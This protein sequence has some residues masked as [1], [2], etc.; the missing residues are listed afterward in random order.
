[1]PTFVTYFM[2]GIM[3]P[4]LFFILLL[5]LI[6]P[7][8]ANHNSDID[9]LK[10]ELLKHG[11]DTVK[12][13]LLFTIAR[14]L[15]NSR[16]KA[17]A[18]IYMDEYLRLSQKIGYIE[19]LIKYYDTEGQNLRNDGSYSKAMDYHYMAMN[20]AEKNNVKKHLPRIYNNIGVIYRRLDDYTNG[21]SY[22]LK[23]LKT[24]EDLADTSTIGYALNSVGNIYSLM[25]QYDQA[26]GYFNKSLE[27]AHKVGNIRS[28]A[29]NYN[30]IGEVYEFMGNYGEAL[31]Y[32]LISL[33]YNQQINNI[34]GLGIS[35]DCVG[36]I[37]R[38]TKQNNKA[39]EYF[40][41][42]AEMHKKHKEHMFY[43]ISLKNI[44]AVYL[45]LNDLAKAEQYLMQALSLAKDSRSKTTLSQTYELLAKVEELKHNYAKALHYERLHSAY[46]DSVWN[47]ENS[48]RMAK[49]QIAYNTE[50]Q[51]SE[52]EKLELERS[53]NQQVI[54]RKNNQNIFLSIILGLICVL[55]IFLYRSN[56]QKTIINSQL[57]EQA[58]IISKKNS[59]LVRHKKRIETFN[60]RITDSL[61]YAQRV[62][63]A[64]LPTH[65]FLALVFK[66]YMIVHLPLEKV[67]GDFYWVHRRDNEILFAVADS[68]G[69]GVPGALMSMLGISYLNELSQN[70]SIISCPDFLNNLREKVI[71][72]LNQVGAVEELKEGISISFCIYRPEEKSLYF[73]GAQSFIVAIY[74]TADNS[75]EKKVF[76]GDRMPIGFYPNMKSFSQNKIS[77]DNLDTLYL[78]TDGFIDQF[79]YNQ[80]R[81]QRSN[82]TN[83]LLKIANLPMQQQ[84]EALIK[85]FERWKGRSEQLD[86]V[87]ILGVK[88]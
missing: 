60:T 74:R 83:F 78:F 46:S 52:I 48:N 1:M 53:F 12:A 80:K 84:E 14:N 68:T 57:E 40:L 41:K 49:L 21:L 7:L 77:T 70:Q 43:A 23:A 31:K 86:D 34:K 62:Q 5:C 3:R 47:E 20:L 44:G 87:L 13:E 2:L 33:D 71:K 63:Q 28:K 32:Y 50:K 75:L 36:T 79:G 64:L 59:A 22:H 17:Q 29:I 11:N 24:A 30:N 9:S 16:E 76:A 65:D 26:L 45:E 72:S 56:K 67:S 19:G 15:Y 61:T 38:K 55:L 42:G 10:R 73:S 6:S 82:F 51:L 4:I 35:Y 27:I 18:K 69:H 81:Y 54:E 8:F 88:L 25:K 58:K 85:E 66:D 39:L 37:Y